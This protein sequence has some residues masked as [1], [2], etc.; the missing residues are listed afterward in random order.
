M[1]ILVALAREDLDVEKTATALARL[2]AKHEVI[3]THG[4]AL[5]AGHKLELALRN[6]LPGHDV[7]SVLSQVVVAGDGD[8]PSAITEVRSLRKLLEAGA[9]VVCAADAQ[10]PVAL[11]SDGS[12]RTAEVAV[13]ENLAVDLLARRLEVDLLLT[14]NEVEGAVT[15]AA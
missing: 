4:Q 7:V 9:F 8:E 10:A 11:E 1:R 6:R 12:L 14:G 5:D 2:A 13:D 3:V 15:L